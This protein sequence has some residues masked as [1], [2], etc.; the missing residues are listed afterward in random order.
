[1]LDPLCSWLLF[2]REL[3]PSPGADQAMIYLP[4]GCAKPVTTAPA[5]PGAPH[6]SPC[7][8]KYV[9]FNFLPYRFSI[10]CRET[11]QSRQSQPGFRC[12]SAEKS[13]LQLM[14]VLGS[15]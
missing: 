13:S 7:H 5:L 2:S 4:A 9:F 3:L 11:R 14:A 1:M 12:C 15:G 6:S 10:W 8:P